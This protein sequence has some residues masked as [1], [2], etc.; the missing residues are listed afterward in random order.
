M[1][2]PEYPKNDPLIAQLVNNSSLTEKQLAT[3]LSYQSGQ[4]KGERSG[5]YSRLGQPVAKGAFH[6]TLQQARNNVRRSIITLILLGYLDITNTSD[7]TYDI[8]ELFE[9]GR[10]LRELKDAIA[11]NGGNT[12]NNTV[13]ELIS[14]VLS[15]LKSEVK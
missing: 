2:E 7:I 8:T 11:T 6:R 15:R 12:A 3:Y 5:T 10:K 1:S 14:Q 13:N 9:L 4:Y